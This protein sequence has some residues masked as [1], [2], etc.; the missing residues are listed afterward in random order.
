M[1]N[2]KHSV[3]SKEKI[4][5][6]MTGKKKSKETMVK[7][8]E[9]LSKKFNKEQNRYRSFLGH[10]LS[11]YESIN[12][13]AKQW[14]LPI[15]GVQEFKKWAIDDAEYEKLFNAWKDGG[16][17]KHDIPVVMRSAKKL[18]FEVSNLTWKRK[19][20][21]S[22]WGEDYDILKLLQDEVSAKQIIENEGTEGQKDIIRKQTK[23]RKFL[24]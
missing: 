8:S 20:E 23:K 7:I 13:Y 16:F 19:G 9:T 2:K 22:W 5:Q 4:S 10:I 3:E 1:F 6:S 15:A 18:G 12:K 24:K 21:Y 11:I 14:K 17:H